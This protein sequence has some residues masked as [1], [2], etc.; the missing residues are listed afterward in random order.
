[1]N[2]DNPNELVRRA[3]YLV[4]EGRYHDA[5]ILLMEAWRL[6][7]ARKDHAIMGDVAFRIAA[8]YRDYGFTQEAKRFDIEA[9]RF[10]HLAFGLL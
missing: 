7:G 4:H 9:Y 1:M 2:V 6:A 8:T 3:R 10:Q 5:E